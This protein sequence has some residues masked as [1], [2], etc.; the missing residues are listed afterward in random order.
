MGVSLLQYHEK[1][2]NLSRICAALA[3]ECEV[4][5]HFQGNLGKK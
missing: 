2:N 3:D 1:S 5:L 4:C